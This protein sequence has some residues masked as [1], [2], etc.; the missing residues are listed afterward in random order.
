MMA[1][2]PGQQ[3]FTQIEAERMTSLGWIQNLQG[4]YAAAEKTCLQAINLMKQINRKGGT[5]ACEIQAYYELANS[6]FYQGKREMSL[7]YYR[8]AIDTAEKAYLETPGAVV[9]YYHLTLYG[10]SSANFYL[11]KS[12]PALQFAERDLN[13]MQKWPEIK[14]DHPENS[15]IMGAYI[16][17]QLKQYNKALSYTEL[18]LQ[19]IPTGISHATYLGFKG[20]I[21]SEMGRQQEARKLWEHSLRLVADIERQTPQGDLQVLDTKGELLLRLGRRDEAMKV[22]QRILQIEPQFKQKHGRESGFLQ[23]LNTI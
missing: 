6:M 14:F 5:Y 4:K 21:L 13:L 19:L 8:Q 12:E 11:G 9:N 15:A 20:Q 17:H 1:A 3:F 7:S 22:L 2:L 23:L 18:L 16:C 10:M